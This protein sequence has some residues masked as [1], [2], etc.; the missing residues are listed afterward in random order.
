MR[1]IRPFVRENG[2]KANLANFDTNTDEFLRMHQTHIKHVQIR[3]YSNSLS[4]DQRSALAG[5]PSI[6][7]GTK[8][9][10]SIKIKEFFCNWLWRPAQTTTFSAT[11]ALSVCKSNTKKLSFEMYYDEI[12]WSDEILKGFGNVFIEMIKEVV[13]FIII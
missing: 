1:L 2:Y 7:I 13:D 5:I 8:C 4:W 6:Q 12:G 3:K 10:A 11:N 9:L